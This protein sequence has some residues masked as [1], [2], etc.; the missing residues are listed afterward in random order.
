MC[1]CKQ[2]ISECLIMQSL[3]IR[4]TWQRSAWWT[5]GVKAWS[6]AMILKGCTTAWD[7]S[8]G[9]KSTSS[10]WIWLASIPEATST[11]QNLL[12]LLKI[13]ANANKGHK[14]PVC[15]SDL[16]LI[17]VLIKFG[18]RV[19]LHWCFLSLLT[20]TSSSMNSWPLMY[21]TSGQ[22]CLRSAKF[23][24]ASTRRVIALLDAMGCTDLS[25]SHQAL[26]QFDTDGR[27][28]IYKKSLRELLFTYALP[29]S[30]EEFDQLW[31]R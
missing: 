13:M 27:G 31:S 5:G 2:T 11:M 23:T 16:V 30:S 22:T 21:V 29:M 19:P 1:D 24:S 4:T 18:F 28:W 6:T 26:R 15:E 20:D 12:R 9:R 14:Q 17:T 10:C 8:A 7:F 25:L 3:P